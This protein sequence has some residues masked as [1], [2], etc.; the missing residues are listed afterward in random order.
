[1]SGV[2]SPAFSSARANKR[3]GEQDGLEDD[4]PLIPSLLYDCRSWQPEGP[5]LE[6]LNLL[7]FNF[8]GDR[9][10]G[11]DCFFF[12]LCSFKKLFCVRVFQK[13]NIA[14]YVGIRGGSGTSL[15]FT[16]PSSS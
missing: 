11:D 5:D 12:L 16:S 1:M 7:Y 6:L 15:L 2:P 14:C 8:F 13:F 10:R 3:F 4:E 9:D